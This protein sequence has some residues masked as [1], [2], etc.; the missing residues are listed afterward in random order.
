MRWSTVLG[1]LA[2]ILVVAGAVAAFLTSLPAREPVPPPPPVAVG[3]SLS[4]GLASATPGPSPSLLVPSPSR[5]ARPSGSA[6]PPPSGPASGSPP[7]SGGVTPSPI[8][9]PDVGLRIGDRAP[10]LSLDAMGGDGALVE[11]ELLKGRPVWVNFMGTYCPPCRDELPMMQRIQDQQGESIA[12]VL[13]DV[14]EDEAIVQEFVDSLAV[15]LPVGLDRDGTA[16]AT[17][18]ALALPIHYWLDGDGIVRAVIYGGGGPDVLL[19]GLRTVVP[20]ATFK[21]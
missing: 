18:R 10:V 8:G 2:G 13:V 21:P 4:T 5:S 19:E 3:G 20:K 17:W 15:T 9:S 6:S 11:T 7:P 1:V 16:S 14:R 12:I